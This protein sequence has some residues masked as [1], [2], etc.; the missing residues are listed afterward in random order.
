[1]GYFGTGTFIQS[2]RTNNSGNFSSGNNASSSGTYIL[3]GLGQLLAGTEDVAFP[4]RQ[5]H[6]VRR[7]QQ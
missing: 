2:G 1:M 5:L 7:D 4:A 3:S 6:A